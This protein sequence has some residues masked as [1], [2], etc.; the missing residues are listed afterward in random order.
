M[1]MLITLIDFNKYL[2]P[3][4]SLTIPQVVG[5]EEEKIQNATSKEDGED[6]S[7]WQ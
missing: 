2:I 1:N 4:H 6:R 5:T 7:L 3:A